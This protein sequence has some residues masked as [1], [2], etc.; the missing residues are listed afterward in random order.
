MP[1]RKKSRLDP[2]ARGRHTTNKVCA[3]YKTAKLF[4]FREQFSCDDSL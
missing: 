2:V 3:D 4:C 1:R